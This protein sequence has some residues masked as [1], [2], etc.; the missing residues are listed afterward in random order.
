LEL[1]RKKIL[2]LGAG[3]LGKDVVIAMQRLGQYV[4]AVDNYENTPTMQVAHEFKV[5]HMLDG[6]SLDIIVEKHN[7]DF[8]VPEAGSIREQ[9]FYGYEKRWYKAIPSAKAANFTMNRKAKWR[10]S[11]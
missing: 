7:L 3:E 5:I 8:I 4:I 1:L 2:L 6:A 11:T 10:L 9:C